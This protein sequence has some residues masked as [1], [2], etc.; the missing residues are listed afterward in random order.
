MKEVLNLIKEQT[1]LSLD[2]CDY[3]TGIYEI[4]GRKYFNIVLNE[5]I[6]ESKDFDILQRFADKYN[7]I[8]IQPNGVRRVAIYSND[9]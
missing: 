6:G 8:Q 1:G 5:K 4:K 9:L 3:F 2:L 7:K